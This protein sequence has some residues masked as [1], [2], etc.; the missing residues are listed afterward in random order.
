MRQDPMLLPSS[1]PS[2]AHRWVRMLVTLAVLA[3]GA[4][5]LAGSSARAAEAPAGESLEPTPRTGTGPFLPPNADEPRDADLTQ[6]D[7]AAGPAEGEILYIR[8]R[9]L[10]TTGEPVAG[11][12]VL[13]WQ[14]GRHG[15]YDHP[16][17][18]RDA[19][20][21]KDPRFH[22]W[23]KTTSAED[24]A[25]GFK[26]LVPPSY[27]GQ[28]RQGHIHFLITHPGYG[29]LA[30]EMNFHSEEERQRDIVTRNVREARRL[31]VELEP[32]SE[33]PELQAESGAYWAQFDIVLQAN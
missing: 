28:V 9:V 21:P 31:S 18:R 1:E 29:E 11:A 10:N 24:G 33:M 20:T 25:Y 16:R 12:R 7:G 2:P 32:A 15:L 5:V 19:S 13:I 8:G 3:A 26:T 14:V 23:G 17:A 4:M 27:S 30:T 22:S 6:V